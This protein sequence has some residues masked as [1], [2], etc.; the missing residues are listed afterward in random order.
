MTVKLALLKSGEE[1]ISDVAEMVVEEKVVGYIFNYPYA[2]KLFGGLKKGEKNTIQLTPWLPLSKDVS[3]PVAMDW[4][5]TFVEP[6]TKLSEMYSQAMEDYGVK[7][8]EVDTAGEQPMLL[9]QIDEVSTE[10][11][12]PDCK[13]TEPFIFNS[14]ETLE[15]CGSY[16]SINLS[17]LSINNIFA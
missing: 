13:L 12:E 9:T 7:K 5:I 2:A 11:G 6:V 4:I 8:P 16:N 1:V 17:F 3:I 10:L 14:D 15:P